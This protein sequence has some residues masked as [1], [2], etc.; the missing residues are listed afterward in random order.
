MPQA[1]PARFEK[2]GEI[3]QSS[4][5]QKSAFDSD[6][7]PSHN[8]LVNTV[9]RAYCD[10]HA[11][12]ICPDYVRLAILSQFSCF[13]NGSAEQLRKQFGAH[14][15]KNKPEIAAVGTRYTMDLGQLVSR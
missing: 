15:S 1:C 2:W 10:H 7:I 5:D 12:I 4:L 6:I 13:V 14:E 3:F 8:G 11:L 9:V